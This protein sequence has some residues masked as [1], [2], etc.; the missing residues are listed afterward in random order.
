MKRATPARLPKKSSGRQDRLIVANTQASVF[1][2][3]L[4]LDL[5]ALLATLDRRSLVSE[6]AEETQASQLMTTTRAVMHSCKQA[7]IHADGLAKVTRRA[8]STHASIVVPCS[9]AAILT[10]WRRLRGM[11]TE[12]MTS[13][14]G[15]GSAKDRVSTGRPAATAGAA[16][17]VPALAALANTGRGAG[18]A[19]SFLLR[20]VEGAETVEEGVEG[21]S[22]VIGSRAQ[23]LDRDPGA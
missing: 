5:G 12:N 15:S 8:C 22:D 18:L 4:F 17:W 6:R 14:S 10:A 23:L 11:R 16:G 2:I 13:G 7:D 20:G 3:A 1:D 21:H 9:T 19:T